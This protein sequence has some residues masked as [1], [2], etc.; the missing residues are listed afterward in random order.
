MNVTD[1]CHTGSYLL[2]AIV[3]VGGTR[4]Q[5][6]QL[7]SIDC[8]EGTSVNFPRPAIF[9]EYERTTLPSSQLVAISIM[10]GIPSL[11]L[12]IRHPD[13]FMCDS[14]I[15]LVNSSPL[16]NRITSSLRNEVDP[17]VVV[18][19]TGGDAD[20]KSV[21]VRRTRNRSTLTFQDPP[22]STWRKRSSRSLRKCHPLVGP[23]A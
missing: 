23:T 7:S 9:F 13:Q 5:R 1:L 16:T 6:R 14:T 19:A 11:Q 18:Y 2:K 20:K 21:L 17:E 12:R 8:N 4:S 15:L 3:H 10:L 22:S